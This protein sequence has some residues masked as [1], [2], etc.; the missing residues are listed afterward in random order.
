MKK[1]ILAIIFISSVTLSEDVRV[2]DIC[3]WHHQEI[4][5][6]YNNY[7]MFKRKYIKISDKTTYPDTSDKTIERKLLKQKK[8]VEAM[9][10]A[11]KNLQSASQ[12]YYY[13]NCKRFEK[14]FEKY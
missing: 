1:L 3:E 2:K 6:W 14:K 7:Q 4:L 8:L 13:L 5:G 10:E 11:K 9:A 12:I